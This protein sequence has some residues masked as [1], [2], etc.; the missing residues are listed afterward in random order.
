MNRR[1]TLFLM[2]SDTPDDVIADAA[3]TAA[4]YQNHLSCM[5]IGPAPVLPIYAY[6][7]PPYGSMNIPDNWSELVMEAQEA[8]VERGNEIE[9]ILAK[10]GASGDVRPV[11]CATA[12]VKYWVAR[13]A[14]V[15]DE[16]F[17]A[18][19]LRA[20]P[21]IFREAAYGVLWHSPI[22]LRI[23]GTTAPEFE[24]V[25]IA[26]DS[27][28]VVASAVHAA[29]P[30][31]ERAKEV[32][33]GCI[34]P[35]MTQDSDGQDPGTDVAAWL[36]HHGCRVT[37]SQFPSGGRDI[38]HCIQDRAKEYGADLVVMGAYGHARMLEAVFGGTTRSMVE[39]TELPVFLAH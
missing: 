3:E 10:H 20:T 26:W 18:A 21:G 5:L 31:L 39:Q 8:Q 24:R 38:A 37:V 1:T 35:V 27:S 7:V 17:I 2:D 28:E 9:T 15:S 13:S 4:K 11:M 29:L 32:M 16:A 12:D 36:S 33:I 30:H 23:N 22:G 6:G 34:D 25:Y 14:R 19:N